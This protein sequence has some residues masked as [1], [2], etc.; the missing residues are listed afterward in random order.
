MSNAGQ[1][2]FL[3]Q[4]KY[5]YNPTQV[6]GGNIA[7]DNA[8]SIKDYINGIADSMVANRKIVK[9]KSPLSYPL[10]LGGIGASKRAMIRFTCFQKK[11][12]ELQRETCYF[13]CPANIAFAD[14]A[15]LSTIDL[16]MMG[17]AMS[18]L[19]NR[20][21]GNANDIRADQI[22]SFTSAGNLKDALVSIGIKGAGVA[23]AEPFVNQIA[24]AARKVQ[25]P[26]QNTSFQGSGIR[27]FT[28]N[29]KMIAETET[30]SIEIK[31]IHEFFRLNMYAGRDESNEAATA[32]FLDY[33][34]V[35]EIDFL[36][37]ITAE[38]IVP[39]KFLPGIY[40]CYLQ[41]FNATFNTT[42]P[43]Y[44]HDGSPLEVDI[45]MTF[46]EARALEKNDI[47]NL[48]S[49]TSMKEKAFNDLDRQG[50]S[51]QGTS[52]ATGINYGEYIP[53]D[54]Q[55]ADGAVSNDAFKEAEIESVD[56]GFS[57]GYMGIR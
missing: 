12:N 57:G 10:E 20:R 55:S 37:G 25:N 40:A 17:A 5:G 41:N 42:G 1:N 32:A 29:F 3:E 2:S 26:F 48:N 24:F 11:P 51:N 54:N 45:S 52:R 16:G 33:P 15:T 31:K 28:F 53:T 14:N 23:G 39:N 22:A 43:A 44:H 18:D 4:G 19:V 9:D 34:S 21:E 47:S 35:W 8:H 30:E 56:T 7:A 36:T 50:I 49:M 13:P 46:Q 27:T 38:G 6:R